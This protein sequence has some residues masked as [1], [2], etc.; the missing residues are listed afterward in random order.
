MRRR[1]IK[2][3]SVA[4]AICLS[5]SGPMTTVAK[6]KN[7][8]S[9]VATNVG[10]KNDDS[11][12]KDRELYEDY[13]SGYEVKN[14]EKGSTVNHDKAINSEGRG[15]RA[16]NQSTV[17]QKGD[18]TARKEAVYA[19][20]GSTVKVEGNVKSTELIDY[21]DTYG[22]GDESAINS[23]NS[24]VTVNGN[25]SSNKDAINTSNSSVDINGTVDI[26]THDS[27]AS[28]IYGISS[29]AGKKNNEAAENSLHIGGDVNVSSK[30]IITDSNGDVTYKN[31]TGI[32]SYSRK[33]GEDHLNVDGNVTVTNENEVDANTEG[34][35]VSSRGGKNTVVVDGSINVNAKVTGENE[36]EDEGYLA[37]T[38]GL[39]A[40]STDSG[41][42]S[43]TVNGDVNASSTILKDKDGY[44]DT[45]A[46][47]AGAKN[48]GTTNVIINGN[49]S[50]KSDAPDKE[51]ASAYGIMAANIE[52][53]SS[54]N[55]TVNGDVSGNSDGIQ[56][57]SNDGEVNI[58]V[59]GTV[60][61]KDR[62]IS[63]RTVTNITN[64]Y[65]N[66][67]DESD[68][69]DE[70]ISTKGKKGNVNITVW[71]LKSD[72]DSLVKAEHLDRTTKVYKNED[73]RIVK[74]R[75]SGKVTGI[76]DKTEEILKNINYIIR[77]DK[78]N[79]GT[80]KL[81]GTTFIGGYDTA[82]EAQEVTIKVETASGYKL[83]AVK[84]GNSVLTK[85]ADGTYTLVVPR[86]GGVELSAVLSAIKKSNSS[87]GGGSSSGGSSGGSGSPRGEINANTGNGPMS[88]ST[89][90]VS[91]A[92]VK[93]TA[94]DADGVKNTTAEITIGGKTANVASSVIEANGQTTTLRYVSGDIAG[95]TFNGVGTVSA[96]GTT[97][98]T[99]NGQVV[100]LTTAPVYIVSTN[101][102]S[103][104]CFI[105]PETNA[106]I[107]TG[108][109]EVYYELGEDGQLHAHWVDPNGY[110]YT[111]TVEMNGQMVTFDN[112]GIMIN[113]G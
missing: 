73:D 93:T 19:E 25:V 94:S 23:Y 66:Y 24:N 55:V 59:D 9:T 18:V 41:R 87:S 16:D 107:A 20:N 80:I 40:R 86:G 79:N 105:N 106:P 46:I 21:S 26:D 78:V 85:N 3:L 17:N 96:D 61:G 64:T 81:S 67:G 44:A 100:T 49:V 28:T 84:N 4:T 2:G 58:I 47:A 88:A 57:T 90:S 62:A 48:K 43:V 102:Q 83:D 65:I 14:E 10:N 97:V 13:T 63:V 6:E 77:T 39:N 60:S 72:S 91:G 30:D 52:K 53:E 82:H 50:A 109:T 112:E 95:T 34:I 110:F 108:Q 104:G 5:V 11:D 74:R 1:F 113:V 56:V 12:E 36:N 42:T 31:V 111:G 92:E 99:E 38:S 69:V 103:I 35:Y 98:T 22:Y 70:E 89:N 45:Y 29:H 75:T 37:D 76:N 7:S 15:V 32:S 8:S 101:G 51:H 71:Q 54:L 27:Q 68:L 33:G